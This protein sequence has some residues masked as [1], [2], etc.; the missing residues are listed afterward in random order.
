MNKP[1]QHIYFIGLGAIGC[2]YASMFHDRTPVS[3]HIIVDEVR[4]QRYMQDK[5]LI[6]KQVYDFNYVTAPLE[7]QPAD[8]IF[9]CVKSNDLD[10]ALA[11]IQ[12]FVQEHTI[13]F[14]LLN[15]ISNAE[16]I[17][18][19]LGGDYALPSIVYMDAVK[20][21]NQVSFAHPGKIVFGE[22]SR[23]ESTRV[24]I[25]KDLFERYGINYQLSD[26]IQLALWQKFLINVVGNQLTFLLNAGYE[27]LQDNP[28]ILSLVQSVG[29]EVIHL[30]NAKGIALGQPD[31]DRMI[32][33]MRMLPGK[34]C[35]SMVQDRRASRLSEVD[36]FAGEMI[37]Q[38]ESLSIP[39]PY[40]H[41][42][43]HLIK[44]LEWERFERK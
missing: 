3:L 14:S 18:T 40:N 20:T 10:A 17:N 29:Q 37:R 33:T 16:R 22:N 8:I 9:I 12:P 19:F 38:G 4:K 6:N 28:H 21:G 39:T 42:L 41:M 1:I 7:E 31:I 23:V 25:L 27:A 36:I 44:G 13:I 32:K 30:A 24:S 34:A 26:D 5:F 15:G 35:T 43:Y 11:R 2:K